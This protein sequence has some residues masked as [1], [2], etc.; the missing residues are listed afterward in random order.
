MCSTA[1]ESS[2]NELFSAAEWFGAM[3]IEWCGLNKKETTTAQLEPWPYKLWASSFSGSLTVGIKSQAVIE[4]MCYPI[5]YMVS[6]IKKDPVSVMG[7]CVNA[8]HSKTSLP[9]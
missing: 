5:V 2:R 8:W 4:E 7:K 9:P 6:A 3:M 1:R